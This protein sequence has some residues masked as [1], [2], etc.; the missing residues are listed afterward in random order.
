MYAVYYHYSNGKNWAGAHR[1][2]FES[3]ERA[4]SWIAW[5]KENMNGFVFDELN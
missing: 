3:R 1:K 2:L 5:M 4:R